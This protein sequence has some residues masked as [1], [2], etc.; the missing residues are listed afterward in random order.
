MW[1]DLLFSVLFLIDYSQADRFN[2]NLMSQHVQHHAYRPN[3][4]PLKQSLFCSGLTCS[5]YHWLCC[6]TLCICLIIFSVVLLAIYNDYGG[7]RSSQKPNQSNNTWDF[8]QVM[9]KSEN[10]IFCFFDFLL[11]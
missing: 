5:Q 8:V 6:L 10:Y 7:N 4:R 11:F 9:Q 2:P 3:Q 1:A